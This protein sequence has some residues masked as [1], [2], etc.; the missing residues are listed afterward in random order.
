[1]V[2][3]GTQRKK[4]LST[5]AFTRLFL[6]KRTKDFQILLKMTIIAELS[7][8]EL[9]NLKWKDVDLAGAKII[10]DKREIKIVPSIVEMLKEFRSK[11]LNEFF[12]KDILG[13]FEYVYCDSEGY[14]Y[15]AEEL[16]NQFSEYLRE[17][18]MPEL[19]PEEIHVS[20]PEALYRK[21]LVNEVIKQFVTNI[22]L[23]PV[24]Q[25]KWVEE[26]G[27]K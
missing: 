4:T 15:S 14:G 7:F 12:E 10:S 16:K 5:E 19:T 17:H 9:A 20:Y 11:K 8:E 1:M 3:D 22:R 13:R 24:Y 21:D 27:Q 23:H 18:A 26:S 6:Y 2:L 25:K